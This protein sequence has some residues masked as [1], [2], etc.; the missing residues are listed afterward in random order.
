MTTAQ[1]PITVVDQWTGYNDSTDTV[2]GV[3]PNASGNAKISAKWYPPLTSQITAVSNGNGGGGG[4]SSYEAESSAN[5]LGGRAVVVACSTCSG[6]S[7]VGDIGQGGTLQFNNVQASSAGTAAITIYYLDGDAGRTAQMS[8]NGGAA[9]TVTFHGTN[10]ANWN[11]VRSLTVSVQLNAGN[12]TILF[13]NA[14][15]SGPDLD[16]ITVALASSPTPTPTPNPTTNSYEAESPANTLAG[17]AVVVACTGCSGGSKVG[18]VGRNSGTLQFNDIQESSAGTHTLTIYYLDGD[19]GR[20]AQMSVN[21]GAATTVTFHGTNDNNW[22]VVQNLTVS[23]QLNAGSN[24]IKFSN[25][26]GPTDFDRITVS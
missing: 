7:K 17:G 19:T 18:S 2:D 26:S 5:T 11:V 13:S 3:H 25:P 23:V 14:S 4:G 24:T 22:N 20:T 1:S 21:G 12:N 6:G 8:V 9:T 10:D 16:R 15:A